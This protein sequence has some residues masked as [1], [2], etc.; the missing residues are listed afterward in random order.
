MRTDGPD[1]GRRRLASGRL[2]IHG[3]TT[4]PSINQSIS[5]SICRKLI[6]NCV[7]KIWFNL[8]QDCNISNNDF[9][10]D[11]DFHN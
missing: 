11:D 4:G 7:S 9:Y 8:F 3:K 1:V 6:L 10:S 2:Q 5:Q